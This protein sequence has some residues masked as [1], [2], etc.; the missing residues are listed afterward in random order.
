M[1]RGGVEGHVWAPEKQMEKAGTDGAR[2]VPMSVDLDD[3]RQ[4]MRVSRDALAG[5]SIPAVTIPSD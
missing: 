3:Q 1:G 4:A 5:H 2:K